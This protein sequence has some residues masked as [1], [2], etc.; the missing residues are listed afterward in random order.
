MA[1]S[2]DTAGSGATADGILR[3]RSD[4]DWRHRALVGL[5][6]VTGLIHLYLGPIAFAGFYAAGAGWLLGAA[7]FLTTYWRRWMYLVAALY[8]V[9]Q[10]GLWVASGFQFL[11]LGAVDKAVE[12]AFIAIAVQLYRE[13]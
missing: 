12:L 11:Q 10:I 9:V 1:T 5:A 6:V 7:V 4:W 13:G 3:D 8:A 2:S